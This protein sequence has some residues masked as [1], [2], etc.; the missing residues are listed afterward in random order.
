MSILMRAPEECASWEWELDGFAT[1]GLD[2][3]L[4]TAARMSG[5]LRGHRLLEPSRLNG[6]GSCSG[7]AVSASRR[8]SP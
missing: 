3:A 7:A 5:V 1:P 4:M 8:A 6:S 2:S